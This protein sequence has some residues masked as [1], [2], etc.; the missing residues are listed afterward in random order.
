MFEVIATIL[1][2]GET[3]RHNV[4]LGK[5]EITNC[6]CFPLKPFLNSVHILK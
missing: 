4:L 6:D 3:P 5:T 2:Y 1:R